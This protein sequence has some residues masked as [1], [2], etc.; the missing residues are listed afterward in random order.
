[1]RPDSEEVRNT[2]NLIKQTP[3]SQFPRTPVY[4]AILSSLFPPNKTS[5][6]FL[7]AFGSHLATNV[8]PRMWDSALKPPHIILSFHFLLLKLERFKI[9]HPKPPEPISLFYSVENK[10]VNY[11]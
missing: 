1:M 5:V 10:V 8:I 6:L 11:A 4:S 2:Q 3:M 9:K 7:A